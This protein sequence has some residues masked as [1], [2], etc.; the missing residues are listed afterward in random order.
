[1]SSPSTDNQE[2]T[3][4]LIMLGFRHFGWN[5][6][7]TFVLPSEGPIL[8]LSVERGSNKWRVT[9]NSTAVHWITRYLY[10]HQ[11]MPQIMKI[12]EWEARHAK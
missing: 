8:N 12:I 3:A 7:D 1:M 2:L 6:M 5:S 10:T 11:V 9:T 4:Q